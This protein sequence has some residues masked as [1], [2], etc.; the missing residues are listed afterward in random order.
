[1]TIQTNDPRIIL[2]AGGYPLLVN[3]KI[4]GAIG[5]GD[6]TEEHDCNHFLFLSFE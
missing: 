1:M 2:I 3:G 6:D 4:F 5:V